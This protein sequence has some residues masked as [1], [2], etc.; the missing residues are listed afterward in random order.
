M[1]VG[2]DANTLR[3]LN[4]D[5]LGLLDKVVEYGLEGVM[6][7]SR[8]LLKLDGET[9]RRFV[10]KAAQDGLYVELTGAGVNPGH[11]GKSVDDLVAAWKPLFPLASEVGASI[12]NTCLGTFP[13]RTFKSPSLDEQIQITIEVLRRVAPV[14]AD[15]GVTI[16]MEL[17]VDLTSRELVHIVE[18]VDSPHV[19][20]NLDTAN[21]LGLLEDPVEAASNLLPYVRTTHYKDTRIYLTDDGYNSQVVPLGTGLV[22][23][24]TITE[25]LYKAQP[26]IHLNIEDAWGPLNIEDACGPGI[27]VP[28]YDPDFINSFPE[29][30]PLALV[31]LLQHL[32]KGEK[33]LRAGIHPRPDKGKVADVAKSRLWYS[34][35]YARRLRDEVVARAASQGR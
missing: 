25:M 29:L 17:H 1:K 20:V 4:L 7:S 26:D 22:D 12:L 6:C 18:T 30:T 11:S 5:P 15:Y 27:R 16:T 23:L 35:D 33:L 32:R 31:K 34:A 3:P 10:E 2:L 14:A 19:G 9:R 24:P 21:S 13:N 28:F 8:E